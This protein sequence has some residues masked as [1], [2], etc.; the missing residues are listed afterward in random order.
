MRR[1][2]AALDPRGLLNP[3][4]VFPEGGAAHDDF[5]RALPT[6]DGRTPG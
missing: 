5:L 6:L 1:I 3:H 2:K 4:K